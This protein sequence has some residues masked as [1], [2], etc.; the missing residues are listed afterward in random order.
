MSYLFLQWVVGICV[1]SLRIFA[2]VYV[3]NHVS[4]CIL[5]NP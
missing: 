3:D 5:A 4:M 1:N 2:C